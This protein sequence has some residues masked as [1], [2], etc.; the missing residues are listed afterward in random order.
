MSEGEHAPAPAQV[1]RDI[2]R[3][4]GARIDNRIYTLDAEDR[5][6]DTVLDRDAESWFKRVT[7]IRARQTR[8]EAWEKAYSVGTDELMSAHVRLVAVQ[9]E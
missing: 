4:D 3:N 1:A 6:L 2:T 5:W 9:E 8:P 7:R